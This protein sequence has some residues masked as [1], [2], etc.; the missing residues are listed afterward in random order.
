MLHLSRHQM[1][2]PRQRHSDRMQAEVQRLMFIT[3]ADIDEHRRDEGLRYA[4]Y[5]GHRT[6]A[7][8]LR[9]VE[10]GEWRQLLARM[11]YVQR[12]GLQREWCHGC[13][14]MLEGWGAE[15]L[16]LKLQAQ[17]RQARHTEGGTHTS[18][19]LRQV[20]PSQTANRGSSRE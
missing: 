8:A 2:C 15:R 7:L 16:R 18:G 13:K 6:E 3:Y 14:G 5:L 19:N 4:V 11:H 9:T 1:G 12:Q 10:V 20:R 17:E